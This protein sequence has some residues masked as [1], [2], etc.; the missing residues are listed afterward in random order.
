M[1]PLDEILLPTDFSP[2]CAEV[3]RYAAGVARHF[4]SSLTLLHVLAPL[5]PAFAAF[6]SGGML[7]EVL[8]HQMEET[9]NSLN[10]YL[11]NE[12]QDM[13]VKRIVSEGDP[14]ETI[15]RYCASERVGL[16]MMP[17]RG[18]AA[19]R[20]LLLGSVTAKVLHDANCPVWTSSH[21]ADRHAV[22]S[23]IPEVIVCAIDQG[24]GGA[25][26][27]KWAADLAAGLQSRLVVVHALSPSEFHL[28]THSPG[29]EIRRALESAHNSISNVLR[30]SPLPG[31]EVRVE[32]GSSVPN[33]IRSVAEDS[34]A[35][36]LIIGRASNGDMMGRLRTHS[37]T[38][39]R[40]SGCPVISI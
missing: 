36:L 37:Y 19:Y 16:V 2:P 32:G 18:C 6:G 12:F 1:R 33:V 13:P 27:L 34:R 9:C 26:I 29:T 14:A 21:V 35:D 24:P 15:T 17:T 11:P 28:E 4:S 30:G 25:M 10:S 5:N 40:E 31:A 39:I 8:A 22:V 23:P 7:E 20:R 38:L 3:A